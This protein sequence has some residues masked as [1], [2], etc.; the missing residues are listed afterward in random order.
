M[1]PHTTPSSPAMTTT[2]SSLSTTPIMAPSSQT[3]TIPPSLPSLVSP[4]SPNTF[5]Q[6]YSETPDMLHLQLSND[7]LVRR[8]SISL[9]SPPA[10]SLAGEILSSGTVNSNQH[11]AQA[12]NILSNLKEMSEKYSDFASCYSSSSGGEAAVDDG[13]KYHG[14]KHR[15]NVSPPG[16]EYFLKRPNVALSPQL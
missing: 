13:F 11:Y 7:A 3:S 16:M 9:R 6:Q 5:S 8:N 12:K 14:S 15:L 2:T 1:S 10:G 4:I